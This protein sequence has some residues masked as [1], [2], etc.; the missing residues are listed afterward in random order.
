PVELHE[1]EVVVQRLSC[2]RECES[3]FPPAPAEQYVC[4]GNGRQ[5]PAPAG[6]YVFE[7]VWSPT[8]SA[9]LEPGFLLGDPTSQNDTVR[10]PPLLVCSSAFRRAFPW[11]VVPPS[12]G[13]PFPSPLPEAQLPMRAPT[14]G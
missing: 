13:G 7:R 4:R 12:S 1:A 2:G 8:H 5:P 10:N 14:S 9:P 3:Y 6:Q 11:F